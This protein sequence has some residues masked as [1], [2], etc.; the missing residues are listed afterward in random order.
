MVTLTLLSPV[1]SFANDGWNDGWWVE[2][3][4][5]SIWLIKMESGKEEGG[6]FIIEGRST[7]GL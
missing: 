4:R 7:D 2:K 3:G 5:E 1:H 6:L